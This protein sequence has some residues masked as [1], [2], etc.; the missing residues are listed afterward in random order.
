[1][2]LQVG[3][4]SGNGDLDVLGD[5]CPV[6]SNDRAEEHARLMALVATDMRVFVQ[7]PIFVKT[8]GKGGGGFRT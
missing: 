7:P 5:V 2:R 4:A 8:G 6:G 1:M 3:H